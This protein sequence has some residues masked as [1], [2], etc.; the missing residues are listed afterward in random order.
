MDAPEPED[1]GLVDAL[2]QLSFL[3]QGRLA[4]RAAAHDASL[5]QTRR[6]LVERVP[7]NHDRRT[8]H[9]RLTRTGRQITGRVS[10]AFARDIATMTRALSAEDQQRLSRLATKVVASAAPP[11]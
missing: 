7:S 5:V 1:L 11:D 4:E 3:V 8:T 2:A 9:V 6:G 10:R